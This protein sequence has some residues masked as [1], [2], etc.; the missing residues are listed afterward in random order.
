MDRH[1]CIAFFRFPF[2]NLAH[3]TLRFLIAFFPDDALN[4]PSSSPPPRSRQ[5]IYVAGIALSTSGRHFSSSSK[6]HPRSIIIRPRQTKGP[7]YSPS[8]SSTRTTPATSNPSHTHQHHCERD[9]DYDPIRCRSTVVMA[10]FA[11]VIMSHYNPTV[12]SNRHPKLA[13]YLEVWG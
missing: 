5:H 6:H 12:T 1:M 3:I 13:G 10:L 8:T 4:P 7:S 11:Y 2:V 9:Y